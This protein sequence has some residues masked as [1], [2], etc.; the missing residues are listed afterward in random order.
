MRIEPEVGDANIVLLGRFNPRIFRPDWFARTGLASTAEAEAAQVQIIHAEISQFKMGWVQIQVEPQRFV[1][2]TEEAPFIRLSDLVVRTFRE[3]LMHTPVG[4]LGIN[5][6]VHFRVGDQATRNRIGQLL[7]PREPWGEWGKLIDAGS[8]ENH[9][10]MR[11]L[12]M[13]QRNLDDR[14]IGHIQAKIEPSVKLR[15]D[16]I[17]MAINDHYETEKPDDVV[18]CDEMIS[19]LEQQF[20]SSIRRAEWI[21]DQI[22]ALK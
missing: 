21:I 9:G 14:K 8:I 2:R 18:G 17:F 16:G 13:E 12:V 10:G 15:L 7:V 6:E 22:M 20:E 5:R 3:F 4:R 1:A 19:I 11:T